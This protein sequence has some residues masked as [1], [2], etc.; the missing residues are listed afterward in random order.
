MCILKQTSFAF[1]SSRSEYETDREMGHKYVEQRTR[2]G[3]VKV[4]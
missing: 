4:I 3:M 1:V 2:Q